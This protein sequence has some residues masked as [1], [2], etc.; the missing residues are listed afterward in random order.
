ML[1]AWLWAGA[2]LGVLAVLLWL[3]SLVRNDVSIVDVF[4]SLMFLV[5]A[6]TYYL[7]APGTGPMAGLVLALTAIWAIRLSAYI[8]WR[9][10]GEPEDHRY[11]EIRKNNQPG[12]RFKSLYIVFGLQAFLA[13]VISLPLMVALSGQASPGPLAYAGVALWLVG[14]I[15]ESVGD[16]QLARFKANPENQGKVL[17]SGLWRYTRHPNYFGNFTLWWGF[18]LLALSAGGWWTIVSPLLMSFLLLKV[19]GVALLEKDIGERRPSYAK[20]IENTNAFFPGPS[21]S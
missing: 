15:F 9:N 4:W 7:A 14:F 12:F 21:G 5:A 1:D 20:Y 11:Q 8:A 6:V 2:A 10:H 17:D 13:W 19:S 18:Y 16:L 3:Y